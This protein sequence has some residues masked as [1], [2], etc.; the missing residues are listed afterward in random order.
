MTEAPIERLYLIRHGRPTASWG[1]EDADPGL[2]DLGMAQAAMS[3][4]ASWAC[5]PIADRFGW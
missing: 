5:P 1:D 4:L 3:P 2:D